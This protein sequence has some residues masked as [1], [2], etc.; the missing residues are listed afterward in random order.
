M[1]IITISDCKTISNC[2]FQCD[3]Y[4]Y[5]QPLKFSGRTHHWVCWLLWVF[6]ALTFSTVLPHIINTYSYSHK[7]SGFLSTTT[8]MMTMVMTML[9]LITATSTWLSHQH[10]WVINMIESSTWLSHQHARCSQSAWGE[11]VSSNFRQ[12]MPGVNEAWTRQRKVLHHEH[13]PDNC[14]FTLI[15]LQWYTVCSGVT[16]NSVDRTSPNPCCEAPKASPGLQTAGFNTLFHAL[17]QL[18]N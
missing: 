6:C 17:F 1:I 15:S 8:T 9:L 12:I 11:S 5:K 2:I 13:A 14:A 10:D 18:I 4:Y 16:P 3:H 7:V